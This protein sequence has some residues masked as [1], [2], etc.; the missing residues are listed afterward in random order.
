MIH[1]I[2]MTDKKYSIPFTVPSSWIDG[3]CRFTTFGMITAAQDVTALHYGSG[4]LSIPHLQ[5]K[6]LTW[7]LVKQR[8]EIKEYPMWM[9][10]LFL[11]TWAKPPKGPFFFRDYAYSYAKD[12]RKLT[13]D[14]ALCDVSSAKKLERDDQGEPLLKATSNWMVLETESLKPIKPTNNVMGS[15]EY[16]TEDSLESSFPKIILPQGSDAW[17]IEQVFSPTILDIDINNHVNNLSYIRWI[18]SYIPQKVYEGKL[19]SSLDTYYISS[20]MFSQK[21]VCRV[22]EIESDVCVHSIIREDDGSEVFRAK[23]VW[24]NEDLMSRRFVIE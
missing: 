11:Q 9:D 15:I 12:G 22:C 8:F 7:V 1:L 5:K 21:L 20:A 16:C 14:K 24:K 18:L 23:T 6:G 17:D 19:I 4:G 13:I 2:T 3:C 10:G